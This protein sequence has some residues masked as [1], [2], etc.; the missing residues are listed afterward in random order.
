M[1]KFSLTSQNTRKA[2]KAKKTK[3]KTRELRIDADF[4]HAMIVGQTG[5]G[6][7]TS[8]ILPLMNER[9]KAGHGLLVFD[10]KGGEHQKVKF[11]AK[12]HNRL[13]DVVMINVPWGEKIDVAQEANEK[14]LRNFMKKAFSADKDGDF[15]S[16]M[17]T[18]I[19]TNSLL[20]LKALQSIRQASVGYVFER[21]IQ[22]PR[23]HTYKASLSQLVDSTKSIQSLGQLYEAA[24][25]YLDLLKDPRR[26]AE[27]L[28]KEGIGYI[29]QDILK[30]NFGKMKRAKK[31]LEN[32]IICASEYVGSSIYYGKCYDRDNKIPQY[33]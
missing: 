25:A 7:T 12:K 15:W 24:N 28:S 22:R 6:K 4:T 9:I 21:L 8:A 33:R 30:Y 26:I 3:A 20:A 1:S 10:Y 5:C 31:D 23:M 11:L 29:A 17:A 32:F 2:R 27:F 18:N 13:N 16:N 19:A 14:L